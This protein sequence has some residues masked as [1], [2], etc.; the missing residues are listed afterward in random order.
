VLHVRIYNTL[1]QDS[2]PNVN[3]VDTDCIDVTPSQAVVLEHD[4]IDTADDDAN[5][6]SDDEESFILMTPAVMLSQQIASQT[7]GS[8]VSFQISMMNMLGDRLLNVPKDFQFRSLF[9]S[10]GRKPIVPLTKALALMKKIE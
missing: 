10:K 4:D 2:Q 5:E 8:P 3:I 7:Q 1:V 6:F 9:E